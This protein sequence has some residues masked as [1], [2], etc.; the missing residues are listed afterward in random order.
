MIPNSGVF[1]NALEVD[2][3]GYIVRKKGFATS[4]PGV[5]VAGDAT[6]RLYGQA[7]TASGQGCAA[8]L[9]CEGFWS[10]T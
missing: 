4:V 3:R 2:E 10:K 9:E 5:F 8:A 7:I 1:K 6:D